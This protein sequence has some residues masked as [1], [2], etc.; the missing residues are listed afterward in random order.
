MLV[1]KALQIKPE[2]RSAVFGKDFVR[3]NRIHHKGLG[4]DGSK[5][6]TVL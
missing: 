3:Q 2:K 1:E 4:V 6:N 5:Q